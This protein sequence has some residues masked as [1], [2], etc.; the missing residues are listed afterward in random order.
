MQQRSQQLERALRAAGAELL[1]RPDFA[2]RHKHGNYDFVTDMDVRM[3]ELLRVSLGEIVPEAAFLS[4]EDLTQIPADGQL[5]WLVD[6]IDGTTNFVRDLHLSCLAAALCRDGQ[7]LAGAVYHPWSGEFFYAEKGKGAT[8]AGKPLRVSEKTFAEA[9]VSFGQGYGERPDTLRR[10]R[11]LL[12][13]SYTQCVGLRALAVCELTLCYL[14]AGRLDGYFEPAVMP[15]DY[16]AGG[17]ILQEAGGFYTNWRGA[18]CDMHR[19]DSLLAG[20]PA[21]HKAL[22]DIT[23]AR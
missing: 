21:C 17:L 13:A 19:G 8:L 10:M 22:L 12:E 5:Y 2:I 20:N 18:P 14:A 7:A 3:Q 15:W 11:P 16:A 6:P 9:L 4:E 1:E 23:K